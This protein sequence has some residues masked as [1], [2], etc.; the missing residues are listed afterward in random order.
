M[1]KY[2]FIYLPE[3]LMVGWLTPGRLGA[4]ENEIELLQLDGV[5]ATSV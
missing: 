2:R 1:A 5:F 3:V 4:E